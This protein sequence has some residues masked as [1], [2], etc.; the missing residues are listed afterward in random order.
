MSITR[1][2]LLLCGAICIGVGVYKL[3]SGP[4][5][6]LNIGIALLLLVVGYVVLIGKPITL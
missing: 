3:I 4:Y 2:F 5:D 1:A 6:I